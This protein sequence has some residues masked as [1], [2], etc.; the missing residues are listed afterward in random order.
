MVYSERPIGS[1][2]Y[3]YFKGTGA[4]KVAVCSLS[5][6]PGA[7]GFWSVP[8]QSHVLLMPYMSFR[9]KISNADSVFNENLF[10]LLMII[11]CINF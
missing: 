7:M 5:L 9:G 10:I 8:T 2:K 1:N 3:Y 11:I 6:F 4:K